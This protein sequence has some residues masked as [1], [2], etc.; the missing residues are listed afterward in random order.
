MQEE[1]HEDALNEVIDTIDESLKGN[2]L[3]YQRRLMFMISI[4]SQ[5][6]LELY[7]HRLHVIKPGAQIKHEWFKLNDKNIKSRLS[8]IITKKFDEIPNIN[9][10]LSLARSIEK[11][12]NDIVYGAPL[13]DDV[14]LRDKIDHF[15][16]IKKLVEADRNG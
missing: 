8:L 15:L 6:L 9:E 4:G 16:E 11:D 10:I 2:M 12:R 7:L 14:I 13:K 1:K 3:N 5:H